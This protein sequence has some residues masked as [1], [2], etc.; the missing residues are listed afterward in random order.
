M[1]ALKNTL[2]LTSQTMPMREAGLQ[3][4]QFLIGAKKPS[5]INQYSV[6]IATKI[7]QLVSI[8]DVNFKEFI[9]K[10]ALFYFA[11]V[12]TVFGFIGVLNYI[13]QRLAMKEVK[14]NAQQRHDDAVE[15]WERLEKVWQGISNNISKLI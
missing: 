10:Y 7:C 4:R 15:H 2:R 1:Q 9:M 8:A 3:D 13:F 6:N 14:D 12:F 5:T 11:G